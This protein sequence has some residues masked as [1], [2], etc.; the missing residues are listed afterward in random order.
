M[1]SVLRVIGIL[2]ASLAVLVALVL[3]GARFA[4]GPLA[5]IAGGPFTSGELI[6]GAEPDW[7]FARELR[8][9][10]R[11]LPYVALSLARFFREGVLDGARWRDL[12]GVA[13]L[14]RGV[15]R[16]GHTEFYFLFRAPD[17]DALEIRLFSGDASHGAGGS[18]SVFS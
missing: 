17:F 8:E 15:D 12:G 14:R 7:S 16:S 1:K 11:R 9:D 13:G 18:G 10:G 2:L 6:T 4:D 5:I 3:V